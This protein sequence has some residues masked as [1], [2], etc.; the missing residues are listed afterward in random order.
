MKRTLLFIALVLLL[1]GAAA[2]FATLYPQADPPEK[3]SMLI[4]IAPAEGLPLV[5]QTQHFDP[6][7]LE[8]KGARIDCRESGNPLAECQAAYEACIAAC[9]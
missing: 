7:V 3:H 5:G 6:C 4:D 9:P 1:S 2:T 8:C